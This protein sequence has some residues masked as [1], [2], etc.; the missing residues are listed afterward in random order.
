MFGYVRPEKPVLLMRDFALYKAVYCG[1][2]KS[3]GRRYGQI[4]R[5]AV[6]FDMT[7]L[8]IVLMAFA[9]ED[10]SVREEGCILNPIKKK[11]IMVNNTLL[12]YVADLSCLL[13]YA[14]ARDNALDDQPIRGTAE[15][16]L[17]LRS[18]KKAQCHQPEAAS[19][20]R[21]SLNKLSELE[22]GE[23]TFEAASVFGRLI[24]E[25]TKIGFDIVAQL[26]N[27][28]ANKNEN[29][30]SARQDETSIFIPDIP[31][32]EAI[33]NSRDVVTDALPSSPDNVP[34]DSLS[35]YS[36]DMAMD[37]EFFSS[38][39]RLR[40]EAL[41]FSPEDSDGKVTSFYRYM[42]GD[43]M[44]ALGQWVYLIDAIDDLEKD[45][46]KQNW[47]PFLRLSGEEVKDEATTRLC[48][49][50]D[51]IDRGFALLHYPRMGALVYN[52]VVHGLPKTRL[53]VLAGEKLPRI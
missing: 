39:D 22:K 45:R 13:A 48:L 34:D 8:A 42:I 47:N 51:K 40:Q 29:K 21:S 33:V 20:I 9:P 50:E 3:L 52:V 23:P 15:S 36:S 46:K 28:S 37:E 18:G 35:Y 16:L 26:W 38:Q 32:E 31:M 41:P 30:L 19:S 24:S 25:L 2:C 27:T 12:D 43:A 49:A 11:P 10:P 17:L 4:S 5:V 53:R 6:T 44:C 7:F 1:L 14:S